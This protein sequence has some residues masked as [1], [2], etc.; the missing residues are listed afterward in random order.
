MR[1]KSYI[2]RSINWKGG[3]CANILVL[4]FCQMC[5]DSHGEMICL[6]TQHFNINR[7]LLLIIGLWPY[8]RSP[9]VEFQLILFYGILMTFIVFQVCQHLSVVYYY[10]IA[11]NILMY[12]LLT[13]NN[14]CIIPILSHVELFVWI[15]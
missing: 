12:I 5:I 2:K 3:W 14:Q 6:Q 8:Q 10:G 1:T 15:R 13:Y 7:I 11:D 9:L 4:F